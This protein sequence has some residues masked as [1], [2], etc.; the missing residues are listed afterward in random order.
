[1]KTTK[2][3]SA[4]LFTMIFY[5][6]FMLNARPAI[7]VTDSNPD[8]RYEDQKTKPSEELL[9][10]TDEIEPPLRK[11]GPG[12]FYDDFNRR[13]A[14]EIRKDAKQIYEEQNKAKELTSMDEVVLPLIKITNLR[15]SDCY[16]SYY[17]K[18]EAVDPD[19]FYVYFYDALG[20]KLSDELG[21]EANKIY[22]KNKRK[23][24]VSCWASSSV[25]SIIC[26]ISGAVRFII[27]IMILFF[28]A[29]LFYK[30]VIKK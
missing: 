15:D 8:T 22:E 6:S 16:Y 3:I 4:I 11:K 13:I 23:N 20:R 21:P 26:F 10:Q 29:A 5:G 14:D 2:K 18:D 24:D 1:M 7:V 12:V 17:C 27:T 30:N 9:T 19:C 25:S 28:V